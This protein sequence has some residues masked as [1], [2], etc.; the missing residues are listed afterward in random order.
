[1]IFERTGTH[2]NAGGLFMLLVTVIAGCF[3]CHDGIEAIYDLICLPAMCSTY[4][5]LNAK[6]ADTMHN[7]P[8]LSPNSVVL[9]PACARGHVLMVQPFTSLYV[10]PLVLFIVYLVEL[11]ATSASGLLAI[12]GILYIHQVQPVLMVNRT[13]FLH[14]R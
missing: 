7:I 12:L 11:K 2:N 13:V 6:N 9:F 8:P 10:G 5:V 1:M 3:A 4:F 14:T